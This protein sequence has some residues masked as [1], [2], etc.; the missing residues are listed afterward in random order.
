MLK[1]KLTVEVE[2]VVQS[3]NTSHK[4]LEILELE[5][6]KNKFVYFYCSLF[7]WLIV[8]ILIYSMFHISRSSY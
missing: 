7:V 6:I 1:E 4:S 5:K 2:I 3:S 8:F